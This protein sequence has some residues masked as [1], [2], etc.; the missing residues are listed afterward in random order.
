MSQYVYYTAVSSHHNAAFRWIRWWIKI[1]CQGCYPLR[2]VRTL[3]M[4]AVGKATAD[5]TGTQRKSAYVYMSI[6]LQNGTIVVRSSKSKNHRRS[7]RKRQ[8]E[9]QKA[10]FFNGGI[11]LV[12]VFAAMLLQRG[13]GLIPVLRPLDPVTLPGT[14]PTMI[15]LHGVTCKCAIDHQ[16]VIWW[17]T[18][19]NSLGPEP[20]ELPAWAT[21]FATFRYSRSNHFNVRTMPIFR[22]SHTRPWADLK[23]KP[24]Q[25]NYNI[26]TVIS[27]I[28]F[29]PCGRNYF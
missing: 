12:A 19:P 23:T 3:Q 25:H 27:I 29:V 4:P 20:S 1:G 26:T 18:S 2:S 28:Y 11:I 16:T 14:E 15:F 8:E 10:C 21:C 24:S 9:D 22:F 17:R 5:G 6:L 7:C 13:M